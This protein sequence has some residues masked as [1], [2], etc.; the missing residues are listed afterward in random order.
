V[1]TFHVKKRAAATIFLSEVP[2]P[3]PFGVL[4][5]DEDGQVREWREPSE[6]TKQ[7][8]ALD[9]DM[10]PTGKDLI[11]A[12]FYV[13]SPACIE[14]IPQGVK[15]SIERDIYPPLIAERAGVYG[16]APGGFW[17]DVGRAEQLLAAT[18]A[19]LMG[20]VKT[21]V[22]SL[23]VG[24]GTTIAPSTWMN[25][26]TAIGRNCRVGDDSRLEN[27]IIM[28][29]VTIGN[30]VRLTGVIV[31]SGATIED[32][33]VVGGRGASGTTPVIAGGSVLGRGT[34]LH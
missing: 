23:V 4:I 7:A 13:L 2:S 26:L 8:L 30:R 28:D 21:A 14:R 5:L 10:V 3:H 34:R 11:N 18:Q 31:D 12:G 6:E 19:V 33:V 17:M 15:S 20:Q 9:Q 1:L 27:C 22:P 25:G 24:E 29:N 16:I 32:E